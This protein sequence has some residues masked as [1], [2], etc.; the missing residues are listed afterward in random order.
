MAQE[1]F[2]RKERCGIWWMTWPSCNNKNWLKCRK[3]D[4][5]CE[6]RSSFRHWNV[7]REVEYRQRNGET[8]FNMI[9]VCAKMV[10]KNPPV[11]NWK[12]N[13]SA[14]TCSIYILPSSCPIW[15]L[16]LLFPN[17]KVC[18]QELIFSQ[19][20]TALWQNDFRRH[21]KAWKAHVG[22]SVASDEYYFE[23]SNM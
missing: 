2:T 4:N 15:L 17:L 7:N 5:S 21:F 1:V 20:K 11:F 12:I 3:G 10:P 6:N 19:L 23:W 9:K 14:H 18:S 13:T 16:L 8:N 22:Q